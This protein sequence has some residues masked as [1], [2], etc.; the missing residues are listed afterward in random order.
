MQAHDS[1]CLRGKLLLPALFL[2]GAYDVICE[3]TANSRMGD[4]TRKAWPSLTEVYIK[5]GWMGT[6][7]L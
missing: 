7:N 3:T 2:H 4:P 1:L 6:S 5:S